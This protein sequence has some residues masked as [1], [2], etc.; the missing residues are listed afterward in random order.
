MFGE[1]KPTAPEETPYFLPRGLQHR[2][3]DPYCVMFSF[4]GEGTH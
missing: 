2:S 3:V 4:A 1:L